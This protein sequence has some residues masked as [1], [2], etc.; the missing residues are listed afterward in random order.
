M[1]HKEN[2]FIGIPHYANKIIEYAK[3]L[4]SEKLKK[5]IVVSILHPY[6]KKKK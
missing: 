4:I 1:R 5:R 6:K 2:H 3:S